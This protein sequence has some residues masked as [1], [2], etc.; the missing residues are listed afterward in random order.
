MN[1]ISRVGSENIYSGAATLEAPSGNQ[2]D[3]NIVNF[4]GLDDPENPLN[5]SPIYKWSI[6]GLI[7]V[8]S[9]VV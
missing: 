5:W 8:L 3:T 9:L 1:S 7:S 2:G 4:D 6:V